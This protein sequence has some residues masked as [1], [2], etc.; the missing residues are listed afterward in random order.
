[1]TQQKQ[2]E[3]ILEEAL[4]VWKQDYPKSDGDNGLLMDEYFERLEKAKL[5][6]TQAITAL[7]QEAVNEELT[8]NLPTNKSKLATYLGVSRMTLDA[9]IRN[10]EKM[11][12]S[13]VKKVLAL[14]ERINRG[15][16][17]SN[18]G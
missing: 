17:G 3:A 2:L 18:N 13:T 8:K 10:P 5:K 1:M 12:L 15:S 9:W 11:T 16:G 4:L 14:E 6:A 7:I